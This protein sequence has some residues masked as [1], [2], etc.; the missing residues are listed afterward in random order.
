[1]FIFDFLSVLSIYY[2][3]KE[4]KNPRGIQVKSGSIWH[5]DFVEEH[6]KVK[7]TDDV[8]GK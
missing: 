3:S 5:F 2:N 7:S 6:W 4:E 1:M 8:D